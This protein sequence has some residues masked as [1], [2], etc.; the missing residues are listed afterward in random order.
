MEVRKITL[1][2]VQ[3]EFWRQLSTPTSFPAF[4]MSGRWGSYPIIVFHNWAQWLSGT[5]A[6]QPAHVEQPA[7]HLPADRQCDHSYPSVVYHHCYLCRAN[8]F[9]TYWI[10][11]FT[12]SLSVVWCSYIK[13]SVNMSV[14]ICVNLSV[15]KCVNKCVKHVCKHVCTHVCKHVCTHV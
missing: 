12:T 8:Y 13:L 3:T 1:A 7:G 6:Q 9:R 15:N 5:T 10:Q 4:D 14:K 11:F 2:P